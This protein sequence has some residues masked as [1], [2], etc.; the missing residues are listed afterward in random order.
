[1]TPVMSHRFGRYEVERKLGAGGMGTVFLA[2]DEI[3][4]RQVAIKT[5]DTRGIATELFRRRFLNEARAIATLSHPN[6]VPVY[7][8]GFE[9][10]TPYF[11]MELVTGPSLKERIA[12]ARLSSA[13][14]RQLGV[15]VGHAL[16]AAHASGIL[17]RDVKP[18]NV[19]ET[20]VGTWKLAD[21]G[22]ARMP[23]SSLTMTGEF[24]GS[25]AYA[26]P[27]SFALGQFSTASDVY[28]LGATLYEA[29]CGKRPY[30]GQPPPATAA[31]FLN[32]PP[33][34][35]IGARVP[36]LP[37][38]LAAAITRALAVDPSDRPGA[39]E[40]ADLLAKGQRA[41]RS[42]RNA[43]KP[44]ATA[45]PVAMAP[46]PESEAP[47]A[48]S[49]TSES[50][51]TRQRSALWPVLPFAGIAAA[52]AIAFIAISE[53][54]AR[55][56][57]ILEAASPSMV[58]AGGVVDGGAVDAPPE[59]VGSASAPAPDAATI[60]AS[61]AEAAA[62]VVPGLDEYRTMVEAGRGAAAVKPL[63]EL[64]TKYPRD[65]EIRYLL[66][67]AYFDRLW[68]RDG[69]EAYQAAIAR[70]ARYRSNPTLIKSTLRG[71]LSPEHSSR[72]ARFLRDDIGEPAR[73]H[74]E[75]FV[76]QHPSERVRERAQRALQSFP[77]RH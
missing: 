60:D 36:R 71:F 5:L 56:D 58:V 45:D 54:D 76:K 55:K 43:A 6:I 38:Q 16:G 50:T 72:I 39:A 26:A 15:Q 27:E 29:A 14:V 40:L 75:A 33:P 68:Y 64:Q 28:G 1:M 21:F 2:R 13:E 25:P 63:I 17:H 53:R 61:A 41:T 66:G 32:R 48:E 42:R 37:K 67:Q 3:L 51:R 23:D 59:A 34:E 35:P 74:L 70:D 62:A 47:P 31:A 30:A 8:I 65:A 7:D 9:D 77:R 4:G 20:G 44:G 24:L 22:V 52:G 11:V 19:L 57:A 49:S 18:A 46:A 69:I 10:Q 73:P 12:S